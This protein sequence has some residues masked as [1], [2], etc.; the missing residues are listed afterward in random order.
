M[1]SVG[2][3]MLAQEKIRAVLE[4]AEQTVGMEC[5]EMERRLLMELAQSQNKTRIASKQIKKE[6][7]LLAEA[8]PALEQTRQLIGRVSAVVLQA[9]QGD[10]TDFASARSYLK[11]MGLNLKEKSSGKHQG[12]LKITK[13]GQG[14][15]R[16]YLYWAVLRLIRDEPVTQYWYQRKVERDGGKGG[17]AIT[18][19]MRKLSLAL[20][21]VGQGEQFNVNKL[22]C[23]NP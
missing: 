10:V 17:K 23:Q 19:L 8:D 13:R 22:F 9:K 3:R 12:Q 16:K 11:S 20:W 1:R 21:Y 14:I 4:S 15:V 2:R 6:I 5:T 7:E 18:A